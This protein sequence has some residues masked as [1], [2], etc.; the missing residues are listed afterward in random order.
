[1]PIRH[2]DFVEHIID[3][4]LD[5]GLVIREAM[6]TVSRNGLRYLGVFEI[7][8][9]SYSPDHS[10]ILAARNF[11]DK[12][13]SAS[14]V[15]GCRLL[16]TNSISFSGET[17]LKLKHQ[18]GVDLPGEIDSVVEELWSGWS[19]LD[20]RIAAFKAGALVNEKSS[21]LI[22]KALMRKIITSREI[23]KIATAYNNPTREIMKPRTYHSLFHSFLLALNHNQIDSLIP[24]TIQLTKLLDESCDFKCVADKHIQPSLL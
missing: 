1:M 5:R 7:R 22:L 13:T 21:H 15:S 3:R 2:A 20:E 6:H 9:R 14:I 12:K 4:I 11:N 23:L 24:A 17:H 10:W 18:H 8:S 19:M 16:H